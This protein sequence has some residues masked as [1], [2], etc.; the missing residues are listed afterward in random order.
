MRPRFHFTPPHGWINDPHGITFHDGRYHLFFQSIPDSTDWRPDCRWGHA[1]SRDL[2]SFEALPD[3]LLPGDG[4]D[5][6]WSGSLVV[7]DAGDATIFYTSVTVPDVGLGRVRTARPA[8]D[9]WLTWT[10]GPVVVEPPEGATA[11]RDPFVRRDAGG[12]QMIV[13]TSAAGSAMASAFVSSD[14]TTW[15]PAG[16]VASRPSSDREPVWTG[17]LWECPQLFELDGRHV[18]VTSVWDAD[19]LHYAAYGV[20]ELRDGEF[21]AET[22]GRLTY[23]DSYY[24]PSHFVDADGR[25]CLMFWLRGIAGDGWAGAHSLPHVLHLERDR[26]VTAPHPGLE[27]RRRPA[28]IPNAVDGLAA[29]ATWAGGSSLVIASGGTPMATLSV[30]GRELDLTVGE[31]TWSMPFSG[32][33]LRIVVDGPVLEASSRDGLMAARVRPAGGSLAFDGDGTMRLHAVL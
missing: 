1:V 12:W 30:R 19:E 22:W 18:L 17:S 21:A 25:A 28:G 29:D 32:G 10:K 4:D 23:G 27:A 6:V 20:G 8:D 24:A 5:G 3:A 16:I 14:L 31:S 13:G 15:R 9:G 33:N 11:F 7:D 26:L 2:F